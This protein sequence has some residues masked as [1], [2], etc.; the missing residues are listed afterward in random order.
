MNDGFTFARTPYQT[1]ADFEKKWLSADRRP[2]AG[3]SPRNSCQLQKFYG[4]LCI[5]T[6]RCTARSP[7]LHLSEVLE[8]TS[9]VFRKMAPASWQGSGGD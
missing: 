1:L 4:L 6:A 2:R 9:A 3:R 7:G 8:N 5:Y